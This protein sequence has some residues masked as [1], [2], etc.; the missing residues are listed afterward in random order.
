MWVSNC[1]EWLW[2]SV[3]TQVS[4]DEQVNLPSVLGEAYLQK[5]HV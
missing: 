5:S 2:E 1:K 3:K 4:K